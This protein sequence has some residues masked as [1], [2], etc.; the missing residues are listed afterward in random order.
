[1]QFKTIWKDTFRELSKSV[2]RFLAILTIILLGVGFFVGISAT[3]PN[4]IETADQYYDDLQLMDFKVIST[5]GLT[6]DDLEKLKQTKNTEMQSHYAYDFIIEDYSET[7]RLYSLDLDEGQKLNQYVVEEGRLPEKDDEIAIDQRESFLAGLNIGDKVSLELDKDQ[8][9]PEKHLTRQEFTV[10]GFV[11]SPLFIEKI[12]RG[13]STIGNGTLDGFGVVSEDVYDTDYQSEVYLTNY[14]IQGES[15]YS[16]RYTD[17]IES[18]TKDIEDVLGDL[19]EKREKEIEEE[20]EKEIADGWQEIEDAEEELTDAENKLA[21]AREELDDGWA[22]FE[23]EKENFE[24]EIFSAQSEIEKQEITL[25]ENKAE[26]AAEEKKAK[27][28]KQELEAEL[29]DLEKSEPELNEGIEQLEQALQEIDEGLEEIQAGQE[30]IDAELAQLGTNKEKIRQQKEQ[31]EEAIKQ[32]EAAGLPTDELKAQLEEIVSLIE[33]IDTLA[34]EEIEVGQQRVKIQE[35]LIDLEQKKEQLKD[36][37]KQLTDGIAQIDNGLN[38]IQNGQVRIEEGFSELASAAEKLEQETEKGQKEL[39]QAEIEL[40]EGE[41]EYQE[42]L[43]EFETEA[44]DARKDISEGREELEKLE[45]DL[46]DLAMPEYLLFDRTDNIGYAEYEDNADR[47]SIIAKVFPSFFFLIAIFISF[48]TMTRMVDEEREYIGIMKALGYANRHILIKFITYALLAT[49]AGA[50]LGLMIGY[51]LFPKLIFFAYSSLYNFPGILLRQHTNYSVIALILAYTSTVGAS[52]LAV[53]HSLKSNASVLLQP[54][55]PKSGSRIWLEKIS[56]IWKRLSFK[57]KITFRNVFRYK[58]RMLMTIF[59]IAGSTGLVLT[60]FGISDS[61]GDIPDIQYN[62]INQFQAYVALDSNLQSEKAWEVEEKISQQSIID[63]SLL[64]HQENGRTTDTSINTQDLTIFVPSK[65]EPLPNFIDLR[66]YK[67][68]EYYELNNSGGLITQKLAQL[69]DLEVGDSIEIEDADG[70]PLS[71]EID[72]IVENYIFHTIYLSPEY[73]EV[74][75]GNEAEFTVDLI[76]FD[77]EKVNEQTVGNTLLE[78]D[79]VVG[80]HYISEMHSAF[81][82]TLDSLDLITQIL[83]VSAAVLAFIILYNLTNINVS[84]RQRELS[85]IKVLGSYDYEVTT[86]IYRE[87]I[88]LTLLGILFGF[89]FGTILTNFIMG[90]M[91]VDQL[92]FGRTIYPMSY[93]YSA[94]LTIIFSIIV[95]LVIHYQLKKIDMVEALKAND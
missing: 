18:E 3:G 73:Y 6:D 37:Q 28:Q 24:K 82:D 31:L 50:L 13:T 12:S 47:L 86:Y 93:L 46:D 21:D 55:A 33:T 22:E 64:V 30:Q 62:E 58:S 61:I 67:T 81:S 89:G 85:T 59:G 75:S 76:K 25:E 16:K 14:E 90:T 87:N 7:I 38:E 41:I 27:Q 78:E 51:T 84:E 92:V 79:E 39:D 40:E 35:Q 83:V 44:K 26:L 57:Q 56:F 65:V 8:G 5:Y 45:E 95:M 60:G 88:I 34:A 53:Q 52:L 91:E 15:T 10:V 74:I 19:E 48:T 4:M 70:E 43:L 2:M 54:V 32:A 66:D 1:M 63:D 23:K 69:L 49:T 9:D 29:E 42:N 11:N 36:G 80:I 68:H 20:I 72:G 94:L 77:E 17:F 71:V